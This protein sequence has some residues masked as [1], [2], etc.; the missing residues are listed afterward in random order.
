MKLYNQVYGKYTPGTGSFL[1]DKIYEIGKHNFFHKDII[2]CYEQIITLDLHRI[3]VIKN[4][5]RY[6]VL[7]VGTGR[8]ALALHNLGA[9]SV[10]HYD[11]SKSNCNR[12]KKYLL[13]NKVPI[14]S[15]Q[16]DIC[17]INFNKNRKY[18]FI[19]LQGIIQH[20]KDPFLAI[21]NLA[22]SLSKGGRM[23]FYNYQAGSIYQIYHEA[24]RSILGN[25]I[26][27]NLLAR[28]LQLSGF[29]IKEVDGAMDNYGCTY[30]HL[31]LNNDYNKHLYDNGL[32]RYFSK[33]IEC[34]ENGLDLRVTINSCIGGYI[35]NKKQKKNVSNK[36]VNHIDHFDAKL[37]IKEQQDFINKLNKLIKNI[38]EIKN[39]KKLSSY[40]LIMISLPLLR[41][42]TTLKGFSS[43]VDIKK[44]II[45]NFLTCKYLAENT[46]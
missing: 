11:I 6:N 3:G 29:S 13:R 2:N 17:E 18:D 30:R 34:Q 45:K 19:Y 7:D 35:K 40:D 12:F 44:N 37:Y 42:V 36:K 20:V 41:G 21:S 9:K 43:F 1:S 24:I 16:S 23:W 46:F 8:Q 26:N 15:F 28:I 25:K 38:L 10:D 27:N 14:K 5:N 33:D 39:T 4:L 22:S 32:S 31:I